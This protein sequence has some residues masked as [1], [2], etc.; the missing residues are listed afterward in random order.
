MAMFS[1][2]PQ[3]PF[4]LLFGQYQPLAVTPVFVLDPE[5]DQSMV[6][7]RIHQRFAERVERPLFRLLSGEM[8][9][10][11]L[12]ADLR[13]RFTDQRLLGRLDVLL[14]LQPFAE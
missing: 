10:S 1:H 12:G 11:P 6:A 14:I 13:N 2:E 7:S 4:G 8:M 5:F 3:L 9:V